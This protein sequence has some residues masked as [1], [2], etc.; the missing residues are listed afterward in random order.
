MIT[1]QEL[2]LLRLS[3]GQSQSQLAEKLGNGGYD[4]RIVG[5]IENDRRKIGLLMLADWATACGY[6]VEINFIKSGITG[7]DEILEI[8]LPDDFEEEI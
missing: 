8:S 5:A 6:D 1:G 2:K 4:D 3:S 7:N